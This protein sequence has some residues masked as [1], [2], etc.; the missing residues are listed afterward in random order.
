ML[1]YFKNSVA[2]GNAIPEVKE[3]ATY[4]THSNDSEGI[5]F[6]L[7]HILKVI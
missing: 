2:M 3:I 7:E 1:S 4:I 6:A 5:S